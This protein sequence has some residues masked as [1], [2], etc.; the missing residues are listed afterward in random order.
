V[1]PNGPKAKS[2]DLEVWG[3]L[4]FKCTGWRLLFCCILGA[5]CSKK[6]YAVRLGKSS[7]KFLKATWNSNCDS[8][9]HTNYN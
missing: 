9:L 4:Y 7:I 5:F 6:L 8:T 2:G 3:A 1:R